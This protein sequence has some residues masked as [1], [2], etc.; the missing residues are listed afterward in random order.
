MKGL[1]HVLKKY[2]T[3]FFELSRKFGFKE[4]IGFG[5]LPLHHHWES[6]S[7]PFVALPVR[8]G[9][10]RGMEISATFHWFPDWCNYDCALDYRV[11]GL[12]GTTIVR[13]ILSKET[14]GYL[15]SAY[16]Y[17]EFAGNCLADSDLLH[18]HPAFMTMPHSVF[19]GGLSLMLG[20]L[21][22]EKVPEKLNRSFATIPYTELDEPLAFSVYVGET[23]NVREFLKYWK[24]VL[25]QHSPEIMEFE[26]D[27]EL[28]KMVEALN[29]IPAIFA[30]GLKAS[31]RD[32]KGKAQFN[33]YKDIVQKMKMLPLMAQS[34][35][36]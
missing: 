36:V 4:N 23:E 29:N 25:E 18:L 28:E 12:K 5:S 10:R 11:C 13:P 26:E 8:I 6:N 14:E 33:M 32:K 31:A 7:M 16:M 20:S 19:R 30:S 24:Q 9:K 17:K 1:Y 34:H 15:I 22:S 27:S 35:L 2:R 21:A 3:D